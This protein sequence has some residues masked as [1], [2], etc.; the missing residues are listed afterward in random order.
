MPS[1]PKSTSIPE[2]QQQLVALAED[3]RRFDERLSVLAAGVALDP[4]AILSTDLRVGV[5]CVRTDLLS[6]AIETLASLAE[7][8]EEAAV[9]RRLEV[10]D[11]VE[12]LAAA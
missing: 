4:Q 6:D 9:Q 5:Q 8:T 3:L 1:C 2:A 7:L 12:R 11:V 10:A